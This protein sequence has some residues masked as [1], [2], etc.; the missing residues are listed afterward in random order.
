MSADLSPYEVII[1]YTNWRGERAERRVLPVKM[2]FGVSKYHSDG[3]QWFLDAM[4]L[5]RSVKRAFAFSGIHSWRVAT[6][7]TE[8]ETK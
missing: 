3:P 8:G 5:D 7:Q 2:R 4:D 1:D 6:S